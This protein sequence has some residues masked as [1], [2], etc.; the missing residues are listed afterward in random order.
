MKTSCPSR[1]I[2]LLSVLLI[3][4]A[5]ASAEFKMATVDL[6][7]ILNESDVAIK[8]RKELDSLS[9]SA[10]AK[11]DAKKQTLSAMD[12]KIKEKKLTEDSKEV[13]EFTSEIKEFNTLVKESEDMVKKEFLKINKSLTERA[14]KLID[15]YADKKDLDLVVDRSEKSRGPVLYGDPGVDITNDIIK[16]MDQD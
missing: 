3:S 6:G 5:N 2:A 16:Q 8:E 7:R 13:Q 12:K 10:K 4:A 15:A 11:I 9:Q 14:L 1:I